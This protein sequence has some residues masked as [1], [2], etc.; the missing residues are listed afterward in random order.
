MPTAR[1]ARVTTSPSD[2][3][4][5]GRAFGRGILVST[6][7]LAA[8]LD[9]PRVRIVDCRYYFD[10]PGRDAYDAGH[11]PSAVYLNWE[12]D[13]SISRPNAPYEIKPF[14]Q[15]AEALEQRG[16]SDD[17]LI[18]CY[19]DE[20]GHYSSRVWLVLS[21][22]GHADHFR[23]LEGGWTAWVAEG[24]ATPADV[25][26]YPRGRITRQPDKERPDLIVDAATVV[27]AHDDPHTVVADVRRLTE[28]SGEEVRAR[29]GG[30]VRPA[31]PHR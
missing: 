30:R 9:D 13:L 23:V 24:R 18:V 7:W 6:D 11:I 1:S 4:D 28:F 27:A 19:D 16:I 3:P 17:T 14:E 10:R 2:S 31:A 20:G 29:H 22:Y 21:L 8:H 26:A 5:A 12:Q 25:P 15:V